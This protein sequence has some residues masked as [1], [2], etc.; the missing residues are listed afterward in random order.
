MNI[1][2]IGTGYVGLV[3]GT[4]FAEFGYRVTCVDVDIAKIETLQTGGVPIYEPGLD[5]MIKRNTQEGRLHFSADLVSSIAHSDLIFLAVGTPT[6]P[7]TGKANLTYIKQ[8]A[9][10]IAQ[11]VK[12]HQYVVIKSTVPVGTAK[13][14]EVL[15]AQT[16]PHATFEVI[17]NPEFLRE[18]AA[19][20]DF[21]RPDRVVVGCHTTKAKT[22]MGKLYRP[23]TLLN[24]PVFYTSNPSAELIKY[25]ANAFLATKIAF[26]NEI[27]DLSEVC[28]ADIQDIAQ[29]IG[30]D[31][32]IG[33]KF[34][35][36]S[37]GYGGSCFPKDTLALRETA[38]DF[39]SPVTI[40][41]A[42]IKA[43][44]RRKAHMADRI[45]QA[46]GGDVK[47]KRIAILGLTFKPNTDDMRDSVSLDVIPTLEK[48]GAKIHAYDPKGME[49]AQKLLPHV[50]YASSVYECMDG[51][52]ALVILTEWNIFRGLDWNVVKQKLKASLIID[53]RNIYHPQEMADMG[54]AYHSLGRPGV[55]PD[56]QMVATKGVVV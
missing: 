7:Q 34:L 28:G 19:I 14:I 1:T 22:I 15:M 16:N 50:S 55:R 25:A 42:V 49:E 29:G 30:M 13:T 56:L 46:C 43:N 26:I 35:Q 10:D 5:L 47:G 17:S 8:A 2:V 23:L 33:P 44:D 37:P 40:V 52:D 9:V 24:I 3:S 32:R 39:N 51:A 21:M 48:A 31:H 20:E 11:N 54:F 27:G 45:I 18:G 53:L 36:T 12:G 41:D 38:E 4:C 6:D